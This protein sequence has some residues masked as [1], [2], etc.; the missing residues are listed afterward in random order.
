MIYSFEQ[1]KLHLAT[2]VFFSSK[3]ECPPRE[4]AE[5]LWLICHEN[6]LGLL[7]RV[8]ADRK[9]T[10]SFEHLVREPLAVMEGVCRFFGIRFVAEM[11]QPYQDRRSRMT[12]GVGEIGPM[13]GDPKFHTHQSIDA[14][15][16]DRWKADP[17]ER[18]LGSMT[19]EMAD[20]LGYPR[21]ET[22]PRNGSSDH[23]SGLVAFGR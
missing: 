18:S 15:V 2:E 22:A 20:R 17:F 6:I 14:T 5:L 12:D 10:V 19:W 13:I 23:G 7:A 11:L 21:L 3:P 8:P 16:A 9:Y 1:V 4:L